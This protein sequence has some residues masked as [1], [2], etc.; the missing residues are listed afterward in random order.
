MMKHAVGIGTSFAMHT[1]AA[2]LSLFVASVSVYAA[3][4][5]LG[6]DLGTDR[7][8]VTATD[9]GVIYPETDYG[10]GTSYRNVWYRSDS[11]VN[12]T[13][14]RLTFDDGT[15]Q[16]AYYTGYF[17]GDAPGPNGLGASQI[18][19]VANEISAGRILTTLDAGGFFTVVQE[20][21]YTPG[22]SYFDIRWFITNTTSG[23][24]SDLRLYHGGEPVYPTATHGVGDYDPATNTIRAI[25][26]AGADSG[27]VDLRGVTTPFA[28][29]ADH[30]FSV[31]TAAND[32]EL[33]RNVV[34]TSTSV[35]IALEWRNASLAAGDTWV[36][37]AR[38]TVSLTPYV[39]P[40]PTPT[41][42][43]T[44]IA[45]TPTPS[46]T[47]NGSTLTG[48]GSI[49]GRVLIGG[50]MGSTGAGLKEVPVYIESQD[51]QSLLQTVHGGLS[52]QMVLTDK[53][54][55]FRFT[56]VPRGSYILRA[57]REDFQF[58]P[59]TLVV[60]TEAPAADIIA[61][62]SSIDHP[63]CRTMV[64]ARKLGAYGKKTGTLAKFASARI[65]ALSRGNKKEKAAARKLHR[66]MQKAQQVVTSKTSDL[67]VVGLLCR[68]PAPAC[69]RVNYRSIH[70]AL[71][72]QVDRLFKLTEQSISAASSSKKSGT[73]RAKAKKL[74]DGAANAAA[75]LPQSTYRCE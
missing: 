55:R 33:T 26:D 67:P 7:L 16:R 17:D 70:R 64:Y 44:P 4:Q 53:N 19:P 46:P 50:T 18:W 69:S 38:V 5:S 40:T 42:T 34:S 8:R 23:P 58:S 24:L 6:G 32:G 11:F 61:V 62:E 48:I 21:S 9:N 57:A 63:A 41:V 43:P 10:D 3:D 13:G 47:P 27:S 54:G 12:A 37:E 45:P 66:A 68:S 73:L 60:S 39:T 36:A 14:T 71:S 22:A 28:Y 15:H 74:V 49:E 52:S 35:G 31:V 29:M 1:L 30:Y 72:R 25:P 2:C 75:K 56:K 65:K 20:V 51:E 59:T